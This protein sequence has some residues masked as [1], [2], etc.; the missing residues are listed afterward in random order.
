RPTAAPVPAAHRPDPATTPAH[1][2]PGPP[3]PPPGGPRQTVTP[4]TR[5]ARPPT[6]PEPGHTT[7]RPANP[8][9]RHADTRPTTT[10]AGWCPNQSRR[11]ETTDHP[12]SAQPGPP[13]QA[14]ASYPRRAAQTPTPAPQATQGRRS[15]LDPH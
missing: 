11:P 2:R 14:P 13:R 4:A 7:A 3:R 8:S 6:P 9:R 10:R 15:P 1:N 12:R 5:T